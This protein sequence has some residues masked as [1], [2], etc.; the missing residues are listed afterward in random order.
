MTVDVHVAEKFETVINNLNKLIELLKDD[1]NMIIIFCINIKTVN[2]FYYRYLSFHSM[3]AKQRWTLNNDT[4]FLR[5]R[6]TRSL[7]FP[8]SKLYGKDERINSLKNYRKGQAQNDCM[9]CFYEFAANE[10]KDIVLS[11]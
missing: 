11:L 5:F 10:K 8:N 7:E 6:R 1:N 3:C 4:G 9:I 2:A